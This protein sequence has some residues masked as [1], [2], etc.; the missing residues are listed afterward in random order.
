MLQMSGNN[1][2]IERPYWLHFDNKLHAEDIYLEFTRGDFVQRF[3][4]RGMFIER[5]YAVAAPVIVFC[6][7]KFV[8]RCTIRI[9]LRWISIKEVALKFVRFTRLE[10]VNGVEEGEL[11]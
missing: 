11:D 5:I 3:R 2:G 10:E 8:S 9:F 7:Y 1:C 6:G 4:Q